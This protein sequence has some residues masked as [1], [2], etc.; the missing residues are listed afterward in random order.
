MR[1][2]F[3][4]DAEVGNIYEPGR[5]IVTGGAPFGAKPPFDI[6]EATASQD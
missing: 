4:D 5:Y 6:S 3:Q 1:F 2:R